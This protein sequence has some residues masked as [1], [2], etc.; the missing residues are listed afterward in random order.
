MKFSQVINSEKGFAALIALIMVGMLT[1]IGLAAMSRSNDEVTIT[2]NELQESKAFYSAE[3]ALE[4]AAARLH[5]L[6]DSVGTITTTM[7]EGSGNINGSDYSYETVDLGPVEI[8]TLSN[9]TLAGL[10]AQVKSY[11]MQATAVSQIDNASVKLSQT[12][13]RALVPIFQFAVFYG[14]DLEIAPGP[15]MSLLGRVHSNGSLWLQAGNTLNIDSYVTAAGNIHHGR[16]GAGGVSSGDVRIKD[17][18][19]DYISMKE[20]SAW[21]ESDDSHWYDSSIARWNG[22]VQDS[23]HGQEKLNVPLNGTDD[24][25]K[26]IE[27]EDGGNSD[28]YENKATLKIIDGEAFQLV[29][30]VWNNVTADMTAKGIIEKKNNQFYDAR[31]KKWVDVTEFDIGLLYSEGY[32]PDNGVVY[33]A[34]NNGDFPALRINNAAE[35]GDA[36]TIA[37]ENPVYTYGDFNSTNKKP[38]SIMGDAVTFLSSAFDDS[39]SNL[40]KNNRIAVDTDVNASIMTGN[41]ETTSSN[42]NGGFENLPRFLEV[43]SGKSFNWKGSMVNLW[44]AQQANSTWNGTYYSPPIR[45]WQ[46]DTDL[47]DP[48]NLPPESPVVRIFQ[49][50]GWSQSDIGYTNIYQ[51][52]DEN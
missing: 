25:H 24:A 49:R 39:K 20:G 2:G 14:N 7:P 21:L 31:D 50:T 9:G 8:K 29:G 6:S 44:Y 36:L 48:A 34:D 41:I 22:R 42:Y 15:T 51:G 52:E 18:S 13:E 19:G 45:N 12:F 40:Y 4:T 11:A 5:F 26:L 23:T 28:S 47:D 10:H 43:W 38:A 30:G 3:A 32:A 37:S 17:G 35:L 27:R 33:F 46:Y 1:L 16:K